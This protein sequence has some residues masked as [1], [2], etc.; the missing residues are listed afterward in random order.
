MNDQYFVSVGVQG[1]VGRYRFHGSTL[2]NRDDA[3]VCRTQRGLEVGKLL[4]RIEADASVDDLRMDGELLRKMGPEDH[5]IAERL[6]RFKD[7][8]YEACRLKLQERS[9]AATLVD[10]EQTFDGGSIWFYFL[11]EVGADVEAITDELAETYEAKVKFR[12][13]AETLAKGCGPDCGTGKSCGDC[14][15]CKLKGGGCKSKIG[16]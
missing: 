16:C 8:A 2:L 14:T 15:S 7:R 12:Q 3:V 9:I 5:T 4:C 6:D 13:F 1:V 11:G 10:V